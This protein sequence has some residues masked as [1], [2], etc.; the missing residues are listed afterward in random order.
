MEAAP[1]ATKERPEKVREGGVL[2]A[3]IAR[4]LSMSP[5][6]LPRHAALIDAIQEARP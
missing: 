1:L 5:S 4:P 6:Q 2:E 3:R